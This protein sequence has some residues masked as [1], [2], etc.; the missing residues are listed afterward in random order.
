M[1]E[2]AIHP[3]HP[4]ADLSPD[5]LSFARRIR[6]FAH[7]KLAPPARR[8]DE[9]GFFRTDSVPELA[10]EGILGGPISAEFGGTG[11]SPMELVIAHE[12]IG[13]VC[14]NTRGFLAVHTGLV[15]QCLETFGND[16]QKARWLPKLTSGEAVGC[17]GLTEE[18]AGSDVA[19]LACRAKGSADGYQL[20]GKKIWITNGG[21]AHLGIV[22]ATVDPDQGRDGITAFLVEM[23]SEGLS[24]PVMPGK[25][26]G[27]RGSSHVQLIFENVRVDPDAVLGG[28]GKGFRVAMGGLQK[29]RLSVAAGALGIHRAALTA[30]I[31]FTKQREQFGKPIASYQMVQERIADMTVELMAARELVYRCARRRAAGNETHADLAA[32]KLYATEAASRAAE[33]AVLLHG[34]RGYS[35]EHVVERL[36]RDAI[37]LRI[38]E[39]TSMIQK[40]ILSRAV[41]EG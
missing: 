5:E 40:L 34:G 21:V 19:S 27:H 17:F 28:I 8:V 38:Y 11:W 1:S 35:T 41:L 29:G 31:A 25:D 14:G 23:D 10:K 33:Q 9:E 32:A 4:D 3:V 16:E 37:G 24:R 2:E 39:G 18:E 13:A 22:F 36:Y 6:K 30:C 12:E 26:L 7:K 15:A 20:S